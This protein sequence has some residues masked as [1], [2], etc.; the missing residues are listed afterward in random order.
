MISV[1]VWDRPFA[2]F[3]FLAMS[4]CS[5]FSHMRLGLII[6]PEVL[7]MH[8][9]MHG[10]LFAK[11][12]RM[13]RLFLWF[14]HQESGSSTAQI[15]LTWLSIHSWVFQWWSFQV[16]LW[17]CAVSQSLCL[18]DR[19]IFSIVAAGQRTE[20]D[21]SFHSKHMWTHSE[22]QEHRSLFPRHCL[23]AWGD[24]FFDSSPGLHR[25]LAAVHRT[26][27]PC[28]KLNSIWWAYHEWACALL[29][30]LFLL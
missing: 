15:Y 8:S 6:I 4:T 26:C 27:P 13:G 25:L 11:Y 3:R 18:L 14:F 5:S 24:N 9:A 30:F 28:W 16:P 1:Y 19:S 20:L 22:E 17:D 21:L 10:Y 12:V 23:W 29:P 2:C 7:K